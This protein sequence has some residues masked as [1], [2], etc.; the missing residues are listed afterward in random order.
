MVEV[1]EIEKAIECMR[2]FIRI[3]D[4]LYAHYMQELKAFDL[5]I[6]AL[7]EWETRLECETKW[8]R[9]G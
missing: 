5:A 6:A 3:L 4:N 2:E 1:E 8:R 9:R 7:R